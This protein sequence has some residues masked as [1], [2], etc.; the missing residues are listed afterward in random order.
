[1]ARLAGNWARGMRALDDEMEARIGVP[2]SL[3]P[4][5]SRAQPLQVIARDLL[6]KR[7]PIWQDAFVD[8][9]GIVTRSLLEHFPGNLFWDLDFLLAALLEASR[10]PEDL[11]ARASAV[12]RLQQ[13]FGCNSVIAFRYLHDFTYGF[14]WARWTASGPA[15]RAVSGPFSLTFLEHVERR[16]QEIA[17]AIVA[18]DPRLPRLPD[19]EF[20]NPFPFS[21]TPGHEA[22]LLRDLAGRGL[23][24]V[25]AWCVTARPRFDLPFAQL[26]EERARALGLGAGP[27]QV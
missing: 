3:A 27:G 11:L 1:M 5:R 4:G 12:A 22:L 14:D 18:G 15:E 24:P 7:E 17:A 13:M 25:H 9:A 6:T 10:R 16:G 21:R 26:R 2:A 20:R 8:A 19:G 23:L